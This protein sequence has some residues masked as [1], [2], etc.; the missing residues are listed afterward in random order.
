[1]SAADHKLIEQFLAGSSAA[2][3]TIDE[4]LRRAATPYRS[5]LGEEWDDALQAARLEALRLLQAGRFRG[6]SSLKT[7]LWQV[8]NHLCIGHLR[9]RKRAVAVE[10]EEIH[11]LPDSAARSPFAAASEAE[12]LSLLR[13]VLTGMPAECRAMWRMIVDGRS[14]QEMSEELGIA[15][16]TLR[17]RVLRCRQNAVALRSRLLAEGQKSA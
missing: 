17:V 3:A 16:G 1:M 12:T 13:R 11:D 5:K 15:A 9:K 14:Y 8:A 6:E 10:L 2:V 4:W 7:Y